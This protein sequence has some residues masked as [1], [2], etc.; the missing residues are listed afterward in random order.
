MQIAWL[1]HEDNW[2]DVK[3][4]A[5]N[6]VNCRK[7]KYLRSHVEEGVHDAARKRFI[8]RSIGTST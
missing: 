6:T 5:M 4:A 8:L 3:N 2:Q 7:R 1:R